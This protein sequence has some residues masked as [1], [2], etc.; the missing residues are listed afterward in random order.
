MNEDV[1]KNPIEYGDCSP[2]SC[3][4][5]RGGTSQKIPNKWWLLEVTLPPPGLGPPGNLRVSGDFTRVMPL[6]LFKR[7]INK[8]CTQ[9]LVSGSRPI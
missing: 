3:E 7:R 1:G 6:T 5:S 4:F 2:M 9:D 8:N